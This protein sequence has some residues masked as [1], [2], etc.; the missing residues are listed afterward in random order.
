MTNDESY[1]QNMALTNDVLDISVQRWRWR[2]V[3]R[4]EKINYEM[5][6]H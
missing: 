5:V 3:Y 4:Y 2:V 1:G 6:Y